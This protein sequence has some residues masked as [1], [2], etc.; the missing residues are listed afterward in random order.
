MKYQHLCKIPGVNLL[1]KET[2]IAGC[3]IF[4]SLEE[5][6]SPSQTIEY[7]VAFIAVNK[8]R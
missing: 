8:K 6:F 5:R 3:S 2:Y 1:L 4:G 7:I